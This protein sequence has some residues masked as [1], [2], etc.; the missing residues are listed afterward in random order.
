MS[1]NSKDVKTT[2]Q[3]VIGA[4]M[5]AMGG[6][7]SFPINY[8]QFKNTKIIISEAFDIVIGEMKDGGI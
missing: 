5:Q 4:L 3:L 8:E 1:I 2:K 7:D 6:Y